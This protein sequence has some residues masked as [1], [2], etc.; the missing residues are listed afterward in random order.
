[1]AES[2]ATEGTALLAAC[3]GEPVQWAWVRENYDL[4]RATAGSANHRLGSNPAWGLDALRRGDTATVNAVLGWAGWLVGFVEDDP[5]ALPQPLHENEGLNSAQYYR[6]RMDVGTYALALLALLAGRT[7][8]AAKIMERCRASVGW[9]LLGIF[10]G[11][12]RALVKNDPQ[13]ISVPHLL[14]AD[15]PVMSLPGAIGFPHCASAGMRGLTRHPGAHGRSGPYDD[16]NRTFLRVMV[17]DAVGIGH[18]VKG[19][20]KWFAAIRKRLPSIPPWGL[21]PAD[22]EVA[23]AFLADPLNVELARI[24]HGWTLSCLPILPFTIVQR[25]SGAKEF[26]MRRSHGSSNGSL[27]AEICNSDGTRH[28]VSP[29]NGQRGGKEDERKNHQPF[30]ATE[31]PDVWTAEWVSGEGKRISCPRPPEEDA[32]VWRVDSYGRDRSD[33]W[34]PKSA[35][36]PPPVPPVNPKDPSTQKESKWRFL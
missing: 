3:K 15:G 9:A 14:F 26:V 24:I 20:H 21:S 27:A 13:P 5:T 16:F 23:L 34:P 1:M 32:V 35:P 11:G 25:A 22:V 7:V 31:T 4:K 28:L 10:K 36:V 18:A 30:V 2:F 12:A 29:D 8:L 33:F 19:E 17:A 6:E